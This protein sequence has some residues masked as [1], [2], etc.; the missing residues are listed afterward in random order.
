MAA[1]FSVARSRYG[2]RLW[3]PEHMS[4]QWLPSEGL[5]ISLIA[6]YMRSQF[7]GP[8]DTQADTTFI[9][10]RLFFNRS[11]KRTLV[12]RERTGPIGW[13]AAFGAIGLGF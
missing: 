11:G 10:V 4:A 9:A 6:R 7:D 13:P 8:F 2:C 5:P 3:S 12:G 1:D